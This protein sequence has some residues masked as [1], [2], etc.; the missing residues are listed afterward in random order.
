MDDKLLIID[1]F[2]KP[3][4]LKYFSYMVDNLSWTFGA[5]SKVDQGYRFWS[6]NLYTNTDLINCSMNK[7]HKEF[8]F[9]R[10]FEIIRVHANGQTY[11]QDGI[12]HTDDKREGHY[13]FLIY[14][15]ESTHDL[16]SHTQFKIGEQLI[17]IEP[18]KNRGVFFKSSILHRGMAPSRNTDRLRVTIAFKLRE[19]W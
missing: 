10:K 15:S 13:T 5:Y 7:I 9:K 12:F 2:F 6:S 3:E 17:N 4:E 14:M 18:L 19:C 1:N 11:G 8:N 16:G